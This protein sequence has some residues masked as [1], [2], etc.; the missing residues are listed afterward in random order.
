MA[1]VLAWQYKSA[2]TLM[3][4]L[5]ALQMWAPDC[6]WKLH[7]SEAHGRYVMGQCEGLKLKVFQSEGELEAW[8]PDA[9]PPTAEEAVETVQD[10]LM[11]LLRATDVHRVP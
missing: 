10:G 3:D 8:L 1:A 7:D 11:P 2:L 6:A 9:P 5:L 4:V